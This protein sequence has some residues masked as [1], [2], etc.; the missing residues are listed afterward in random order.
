[1]KLLIW[2]GITVGGTLGG[3]VGAAF[4][5]GNWFGGWSIFLGVVGSFVGIWAGYKASQYI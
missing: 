1:M 5:H 3:W 4:D 2:I